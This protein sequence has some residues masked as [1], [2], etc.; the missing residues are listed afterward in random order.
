MSEQFVAECNSCGVLERGDLETA[1]DAA[2]DHDQFHDVQVKR[3]A[4]DGGHCVDDIGQK[5][6]SLPVPALFQTISLRSES[7]E[8]PIFHPDTNAEYPNTAQIARYA[9]TIN[10]TP[11]Q[12][13]TYSVVTVLLTNM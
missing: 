7:I 4:T 9:S 3:V 8:H 2:E 11:L 12:L 1:G 5:E 10:R 13:V 6:A